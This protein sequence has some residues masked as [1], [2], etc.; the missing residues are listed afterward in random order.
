MRI[1]VRR[2]NPYGLA[3]AVAHGPGVAEGVL[4]RAAAGAAAAAVDAAAPNRAAGAPGFRGERAI[5]SLSHRDGVGAAVAARTAVGI[6]LERTGAV[7]PQGERLFATEAERCAPGRPA[8]GA[9]LWALKEAAW[10]AFRCPRDLP[11]KELE[12]ELRPGA[13]V[14]AVRIAGERH[15]TRSALRRPWRG[16]IVALVWAEEGQ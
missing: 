1:H 3:W 12:L 16:W 8:D 4:A 2:E 10:K 6:D 11:F 14:R 9:V 15:P 7:P 5:L 13:A